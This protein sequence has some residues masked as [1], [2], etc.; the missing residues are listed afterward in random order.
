MQLSCSQLTLS[1]IIALIM[2]AACRLMVTVLSLDGFFGR[3]WGSHFTHSHF[4][5]SFHLH[6]PMGAAKVRK[7]HQFLRSGAYTRTQWKTRKSPCT[8]SRICVQLETVTPW[9]HSKLDWRRREDNDRDAAETFSMQGSGRERKQP[10]E[11]RET[12]EAAKSLGKRQK[13]PY[14][15]RKWDSSVKSKAIMMQPKSLH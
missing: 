4:P 2:L 7:W 12:Q 3:K 14:P 15:R 13:E 1:V 6:N 5:W 10:L 8:A 11:R 9:R